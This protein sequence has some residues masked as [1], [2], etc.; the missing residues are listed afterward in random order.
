MNHLLQTSVRTAHCH[1]YRG[2][3]GGVCVCGG[4][5]GGEGEGYLQVNDKLVLAGVMTCDMEILD[6]NRPL[7]AE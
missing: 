4:G 2:D 7:G 6:K 5:R 1:V 3:R